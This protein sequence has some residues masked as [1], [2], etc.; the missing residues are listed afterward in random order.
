[1]KIFDTLPFALCLLSTCL[2]GQVKAQDEIV[3]PLGMRMVPEA[4]R[5]KSSHNE[6]FIYQYTP[7]E[8]PLMDDFSIDR[9][10][11]RW[12]QVGDD[13]VTLD[14]VIQHL[15]VA[16]N[17]TPDMA[18]SLDT[19]FYYTTD[20]T[21]EQVSTT[22][23][24]LPEIIVTVNDLDVYPV[25]STDVTAWPAYNVFDT[26][27]SPSP[28]TIDL[29]TP[30]LQQ[31]SL[32]VYIVAPDN[33][34]YMMNNEAT[35]L[36]LWE[37]DDVFING[38]YPVL[39]PTIGVATF[40]GLSRTGIPYDFMNYS[41]YGIADRLTSVPI[42]MGG[43]VAADS[44]YLSFF[45]QA[46][47][48]SGDVFGQAG[49]S[50]VLEFYAP[51]EDL[52][53]RVWRSPYDAM[54]PSEQPPFDQVMIPIKEF[55]YLQNGFKMRFFNYATLSGSFDHWHLDYVR[56]AKER[57]H[58]DT[59][60]V[61][62]AY[63]YPHSTLLETYTS[64][65][66]NKFELQPAT[67]MANSVTL[68][69]RNLDDDDRFITYGYL[70]GDAEGPLT[71]VYDDGTNT[72]NNASSVFDSNHPV[73]AIGYVYD[74]PIAEDANFYEAKFWT[75]ATPDINRYND[76]TS[77]IQEI[78]NYYA[79]DDGSAEASYSLNNAAG[80][81]LAYRFDL[82]GGDSLRAIRMYFTPSA[83]PPPA[84]HPT[85]GSFLLTIW[86]SLSPESIQ[87]QNFT[88]SSPEYRHDGLYYFVEYPLDSVIYVEGT[89][90]IGWTQTNNV[91][92][93]LGLDRNRN[94]GNRIT[95][96]VSGTWQNST[97]EGSLMMRPV[98][99]AAVDPWAGMEEFDTDEVQ[100][101]PNPASEGFNIRMP[102]DVSDAT[103][104][105]LDALGRVVKQDRFRN[106]MFVPAEGL[107]EGLHM[108]R[109]IG[110]DGSVMA[111]TRV[112]VQR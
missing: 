50:L 56:L 3:R 34:I 7:Q 110:D 20:I 47:G 2:T 95:Y 111:V 99:V 74:A 19:T 86:N 90:Y 75:N 26:I 18:F 70:A 58:D 104:E 14:Q 13:G 82:L 89:I 109:I 55:R 8:L 97:V 80:G 5:P 63:V 40:D 105:M 16:G 17:S 94:N 38:T 78:S 23:A 107:S 29:V 64:V 85:T 27:Q 61:D 36:V 1:M 49:D 37:D 32:M 12:A 96:N 30:D 54:V 101:Y 98:M 69:Q 60:I 65:P 15:A 10:R 68:Q 4:L 103:V 9:T 41:S 100:L 62:V 91:A 106:N 72:S 22:R 102:N 79:Y 48:L 67:L 45:Y 73:S 46:R 84:G 59:T 39:P 42:D 108:V 76:T 43:L 28:D 112:I 24:P 6:H 52:W 92:M 88:F 66:Y 51:Q 35:P 31:D 11:R 33:G 57:T 25:T 71:M 83:N 81:K 44:I 77:F 87:H 21:D 53:Y 93:N